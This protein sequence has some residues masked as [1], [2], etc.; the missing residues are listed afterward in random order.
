MGIE[1]ISHSFCFFQS[2][3]HNPYCSYGSKPTKRLCFILSIICTKVNVS[4]PPTFGP[5]VNPANGIYIRKSATENV[6]FVSRKAGV[7]TVLT[8]SLRAWP[9]GSERTLRFLIFDN[10]GVL[11]VTILGPLNANTLSFSTVNQVIATN[12]PDRVPM[13]VGVAN[14]G[15]YSIN[16]MLIA[17]PRKLV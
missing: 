17:G 8:T 14:A 12:V 6:V 13:F 15:N 1:L 3:S 11:S 2:S 16:S 7:E 10:N 4:F 9:P 5:L